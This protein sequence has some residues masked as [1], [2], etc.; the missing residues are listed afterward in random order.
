MRYY[1]IYRNIIYIILLASLAMNIE[2]YFENKAAKKI[3][4]TNLDL[5]KSETKE[6]VKYQKEYDKNQTS[7]DFLRF[8]VRYKNLETN[9]TKKWLS[10]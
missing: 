7:P 6:L 9:E 2:F 10:I 3:I 5:N 1:W 4:S 8:T